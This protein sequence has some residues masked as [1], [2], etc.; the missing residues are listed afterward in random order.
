MFAPVRVRS[1]KR[2]GCSVSV[3]ASE[4]D[5]TQR[6]PNLAILATPQPGHDEPSLPFFFAADELHNEMQ[7]SLT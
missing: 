4:R 7:L 1:L 5:R 3:T 2:L 6:T